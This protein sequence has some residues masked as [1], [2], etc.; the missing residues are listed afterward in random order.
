LGEPI[1]FTCTID[2]EGPVA[3]YMLIDVEDDTHLRD[4]FD[5]AYYD[6]NSE[7][8]L[9]LKV[10]LTGLSEGVAMAKLRI[11]ARANSSATHSI[12]LPIEVTGDEW[13]GLNSHSEDSNPPDI[14]FINRLLDDLAEWLTENTPW[15]FSSMHAGI[16]VLFSGLG[17]IGT[18][19]LY[20]ARNVWQR[21]MDQKTTVEQQTEARFDAL[22]RGGKYEHHI[23]P[24]IPQSPEVV[25]QRKK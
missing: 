12:D 7:E 19:R 16:I 5:P 10:T 13:A 8:I 11:F 18:V 17:V 22:R 14:S 3:L 4:Q 21:N 23:E 25:I 24:T 2:N 15:Q 20:R 6:L 1:T 9:E